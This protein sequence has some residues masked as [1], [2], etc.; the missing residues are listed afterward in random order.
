[1]VLNMRAAVKLEEERAKADQIMD[2]LMKDDEVR[3]TI[4]RKIS[5]LYASSQLP[6]KSRATSYP[7]RQK[8]AGAFDLIFTMRPFVFQFLSQ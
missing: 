8:P 3:K 7:T 2:M 6:R 5:E 1:M 4:V